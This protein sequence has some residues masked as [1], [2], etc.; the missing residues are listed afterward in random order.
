M[1]EFFGEFCFS[2]K[3]MINALADYPYTELLHDLK[4]GVQKHKISKLN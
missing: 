1:I 4:T 2:H 3:P